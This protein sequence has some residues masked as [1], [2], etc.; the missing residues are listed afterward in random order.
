[1]FRA[2]TFISISNGPVRFSHI[3][4]NVHDAYDVSLSN[5]KTSL[6]IEALC[7]NLVEDKLLQ[8]GRVQLSVGFCG[9]HV[10]PI[11]PL[12]FANFRGIHVTEKHDNS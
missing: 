4:I 3:Y 11:R 8:G 9:T 2:C 5:P 12:A 7:L 6:N 1:M 10:T